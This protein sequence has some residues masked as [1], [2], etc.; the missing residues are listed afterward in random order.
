MKSIRPIII[1]LVFFV[2][3]VA[4]GQTSHN[5]YGHFA[6]IGN[7]SFDYSVVKVMLISHFGRRETKVSPD[8]KFVF[9]GVPLSD[10]V[11]V[12]ATG[13]DVYWY[14][15]SIPRKYSRTTQDLE[16][17]IT[18]NEAP[19]TVDL[20]IVKNPVQLVPDPFSVYRFGHDLLEVLPHR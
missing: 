12:F 6:P 9:L 14:P 5:I 3:M 11:R 15:I 16:I 1:S 17:T 19:N 10:S 13:A 8:G 4:N 20:I 18:G 2:S 7:L